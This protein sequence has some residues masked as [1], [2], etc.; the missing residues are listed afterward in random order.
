MKT[1]RIAIS[2]TFPAKHPRAGEPTFFKQKIEM[3]LGNV[4]ERLYIGEGVTALLNMPKFHTIRANYPLWKRRID[5]VNAGEAVLVLY[6]WQGK[7]YRSKTLE[8]L[9]FDKDSGIDVQ[10]VVIGFQDDIVSVEI[11]ENHKSNYY[12]V[13]KLAENDGLS[14]EDFRAWFKG[15]DRSKPMAIIQFTN[16]KY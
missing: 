13:S 6:E 11:V 16:F 4:T 5:E 14:L 1:Y 9:R 15:Y 10:K 12:S 3:G 2:R 8:I 7:P